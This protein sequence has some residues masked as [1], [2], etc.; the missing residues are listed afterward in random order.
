M[1]V[2]SFSMQV[3]DI[4][5]SGK[6]HVLHFIVQEK[7]ILEHTNARCHVFY[8]LICKRKIF[9]SILTSSVL[10]VHF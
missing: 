6:C 2:L 10:C 3:K 7:N 1:I 9:L 5:Q 4:I 8:I